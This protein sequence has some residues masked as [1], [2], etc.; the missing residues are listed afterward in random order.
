ME[1]LPDDQVR[2]KLS[3]C[4]MCDGVV[5]ASVEHMMDKK[6]KSEFAN[7]VMEYNLSVTSIPL[8]E[9]RKNTLAWCKCSRGF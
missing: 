6:S 4:N 3:S 2:I 7:E 9:Y 1:N 5:R 8:L